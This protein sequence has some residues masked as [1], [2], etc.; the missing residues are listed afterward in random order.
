MKSVEILSILDGD[1]VPAVLGV[2]RVPETNVELKNDD[3]DVGHVPGKK[4]KGKTRL[5]E[6]IRF[7]VFSLIFPSQ[8]QIQNIISYGKV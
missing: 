8:N 7:P 1:D 4:L 6:K 2:G 3:L 5:A